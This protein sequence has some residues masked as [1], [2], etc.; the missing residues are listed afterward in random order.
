MHMVRN[1]CQILKENSRSENQVEIMRSKTVCLIPIHHW[2]FLLRKYN[3]VERWVMKNINVLKGSLP[4]GFSWLY[5]LIKLVL[6]RNASYHMRQFRWLTIT[7][8]GSVVGIHFKCYFHFVWYSL[9]FVIIM[10]YVLYQLIT[11]KIDKSHTFA[12]T[13]LDVAEN[14]WLYNSSIWFHM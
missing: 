3:R 11:I 5:Y 2:D 10:I 1:I 7:F 13:E 9:L 6:R 12:E 8:S 14:I 4:K